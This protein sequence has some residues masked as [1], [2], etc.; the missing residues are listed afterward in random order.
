M[1]KVFV[2][3][4]SGAFTVKN[5]TAFWKNKGQWILEMGVL[6][7]VFAVFAFAAYNGVRE[8]SADFFARET[9][10]E[11][12]LMYAGIFAGV[13]PVFYLIFQAVL[14]CFYRPVYK[15]NVSDG[16]LPGCSVIVPAYNEGSAVAE[17]L[18]A[19]LKSDYPADKLEI[20]AINDGSADDTWNWMTL[21]ASESGTE[22]GQEKRLVYRFQS[23]KT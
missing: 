7:A 3:L 22:S 18:R 10:W 16:E 13:V 14:V 4:W 1:S 12:I 20:I 15:D 21:A 2:K 23:G 8:Q 9:V 19:L 5:S 6:F 11:K 17:T